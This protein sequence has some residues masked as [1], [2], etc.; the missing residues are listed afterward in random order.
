MTKAKELEAAVSTLP[1]EEYRKFRRWFLE[2]D[3][4]RWDREIEE[5]RGLRQSRTTLRNDRDS[6]GIPLSH[7]ALR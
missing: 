6:H 3:W 5:E 2:K 1:D 4:E 7:I